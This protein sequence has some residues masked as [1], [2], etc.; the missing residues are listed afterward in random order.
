MC[1]IGKNADME[2]ELFVK[3]FPENKNNNIASGT[4]KKGSS[5]NPQSNN[6]CKYIEMQKHYNVII[7]WI[8]PMGS[9]F[10]VML[11]VIKNMKK[12][13]A[14]LLFLATQLKPLMCHVLIF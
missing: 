12:S 2:Y 10:G 11:S 14:F 13:K 8:H 7:S 9:Y 5:L 1:E 4:P 3:G 6:F